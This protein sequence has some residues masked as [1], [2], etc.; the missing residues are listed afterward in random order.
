MNFVNFSDVER[1]CTSGNR[2]FARRT[3]PFGSPNIGATVR[4]W[5]HSGYGHHSKFVLVFE[6]ILASSHRYGHPVLRRKNAFV[7]SNKILMQYL[8]KACFRKS[9]IFSDTKT[10]RSPIFCKW[11]VELT[12][13]KRIAIRS[14]SS[15]VRRR[16]KISSRNF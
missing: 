3:D 15:C 13:R 1:N 12:D 8:S 9:F 5:C 11:S 14:A 2:L 6:R 4:F 7:S 10:I 16:R